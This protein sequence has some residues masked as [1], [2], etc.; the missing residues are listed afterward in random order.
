MIYWISEFGSR[1]ESQ[2]LVKILNKW[3][4]FFKFASIFYFFFSSFFKSLFSSIF[5]NIYDVTNGD[6][7]Y[8]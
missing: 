8:F 2:R 5:G 6:I 4:I 7:V 3:N 1:F